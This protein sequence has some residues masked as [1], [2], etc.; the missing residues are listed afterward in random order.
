MIELPN[1]S[2]VNSIGMFAINKSIAYTTTFQ[3]CIPL[4]KNLKNTGFPLLA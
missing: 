4:S 1:T 3:K 2:Q